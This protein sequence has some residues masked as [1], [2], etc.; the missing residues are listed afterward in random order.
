M[1]KEVIAQRDPKSPISEIFRTLRTNIQFMNTSKGLK[2]LLVTSTMPEEG[3]S[4]VTANLAVTFAQAG[5]RV[6]LI[7]ADMRKGR[8][9]AVFEVNK[10][11]GLSNYLSNIDEF[12]RDKEVNIVNYIKETEVDNL[13]LIP[14]GDVPPNP[15]ELLV[16]EK[17]LNMMEE[18]KDVFDLIIFDATPSLLVTDAIILSRFVDSTI[19][20]AEHKVTKTENLKKIKTDIENVGGK[21][22]GIIVNKEKINSKKYNGQYYYYGEK[23]VKN[24]KKQSGSSLKKMFVEDIKALKQ[25]SKQERINEVENLKKEVI[26]KSEEPDEKTISNKTN[27]VIAEINKYLENEKAK[28]NENKGND[29]QN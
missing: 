8:Q 16:S 14:A 15:S 29:G 21:V 13:F 19:I 17:M 7:D 28:L 25:S 26:E 12:G 5:K 2:T 23:T 4:W 18:L 6:V 1:K 22:A 24:Q 3:K 9:H 11:P 27:E 10:K 20:V